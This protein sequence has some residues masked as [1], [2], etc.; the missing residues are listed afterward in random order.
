MK[1]LENQ[2]LLFDEDCPLCQ[3]Y[4]TSFIKAGMLDENGKKSFSNLSEDEK[5]FIDI[6]RAS[7]EI[8]LVDNKNKTVIY[9]IDSL[10]K[11][12]ENSFPWMEK[13]GNFAVIKFLLKKLYSFISYNRKVIIPNKKT[14][15]TI[16]CTPSFNYKYRILYIAFAILMT[17]LTLYNFSE[18]ITDLPKGNFSKELILALGQILFQS[19]FL[20]KFDKKVILNYVGNLM[21]VSIFGSLL[22][23]PILILN[24]FLSIPEIM[25]I[26]WFGTTVL[27]M[28]LEHF[29]RIK[30]L[31]LPNYLCYTWV[32]FPLSFLILIL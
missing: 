10:L 4:T 23:T 9:G 19:L 16:Q 5:N 15:K 32:L 26:G 22:L 17:D 1:T 7:N 11:V 25:I 27:I 2:T 29:R 20:M 14:E 24:Q 12:I 6:E 8:A 13:V 18:L 3:V 28:F 30:L 31:E 21:T